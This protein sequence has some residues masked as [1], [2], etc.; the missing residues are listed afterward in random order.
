MMLATAPSKFIIDTKARTGWNAE[1]K[2]NKSTEIIHSRF[3]ADILGCTQYRR[4]APSHAVGVKY[5][6]VSKSRYRG[7]F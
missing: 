2:R 6:F 5:P 7:Y 3:D 4:A 1:M